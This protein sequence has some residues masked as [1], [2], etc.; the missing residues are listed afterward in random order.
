MNADHHD[1]MKLSDAQRKPSELKKS[2]T[3]GDAEKFFHQDD[4]ETLTKT[5]SAPTEGNS[6]KPSYSKENLK[7]SSKNVKKFK[8]VVLFS[9]CAREKERWFHK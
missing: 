6:E 7:D 8:T 3:T 5:D 1:E 4:K 2:A 9:R